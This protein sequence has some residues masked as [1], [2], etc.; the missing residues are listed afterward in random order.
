MISK[1]AKIV[2]GKCTM[3]LVKLI[4]FFVVNTQCNHSLLQMHNV[5]GKIANVMDFP[6]FYT[7]NF[8]QKMPC[9][10]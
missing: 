10:A 1:I 6:T 9:A 3:W 8:I 2:C 7:I 4:T 5:I